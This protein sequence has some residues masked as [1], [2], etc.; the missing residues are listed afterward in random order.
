MSKD[1]KKD[2]KKE[3]MLGL[4]VK[5]SE[6]ISEWY[7]Q[8]ITKADLIDYTDVSGCIV[9]KPYCY[10]IWDTVKNETDKRFKKVGIKNCYFP[11]FIPEKFL[12]KEEE[13]IEGFAPEVAWVTHA[14]SSKLNE[15]LAIRPT[16]ETIMYPSFKK[17]IRS[18]KDLPLRLNQWNN[19]VRWE[20]KNPV[21]LMRSRE[22]LWNEGHT[23]FATKAEAEA[24]KDEII[25][26]Y[27][28]I[29]KDY[30]GI[31]G[32]PGFKTEKERFAG[33]EYTCS[34]EFF[35]ESGKS[36]QGPDFH[37][38][39][40][41]FSKAFDISFLNQEG[42]R[43]YAWQNTFAITTRMLGVLFMMHGDDKGLVLPP[44][45][46]PHQAVIIPILFEKTKDIVLKKAN[47]LA[48]KL[49]IRVLVDDRDYYTPGWKYNEW[50]F[51]GVPL[52]IELGPRDLENK[53]VVLVR[54]DT[55]EKEIVKWI[56]LKKKTELVLEDIHR[57]LYER[58]K[59]IVETNLVKVKDWKEFLKAEKEKKWI[60]AMH[61]GSAKCE[62]EI[63]DKTQGV[64]T[65]CIPFDQPKLGKCVHCGKDAK[66]EVLFSKSY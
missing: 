12:T 29:L 27:Q 36:I 24:E 13:H 56:N 59:K 43:E 53:Q 14:G 41:K 54:R 31:Y 2:N 37:H 64:K 61:C 40:Q 49:D 60:K 62:E 33:A 6:N 48:K 9:F 38:D 26:I 1:N 22:F 16:S 23:V 32:I 66:Y 21:P 15:R 65:N 30:M 7:T 44:K 50:E 3:N 18:W 63:K 58:S 47:E 57:S 35:L 20:F 5:K 55:G 8:V 46:A 34:I 4:T 25:G 28:E 11:I 17:W 45:L 51:K 39:G 52:R 10:D 19:V 42:K